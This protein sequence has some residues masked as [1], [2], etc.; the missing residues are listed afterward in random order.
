MA[1]TVNGHDVLFDNR[2]AGRLPRLRQW[3]VPGTDRH[4]FLRDGAM[5]FILIHIALWFHETVERLN[6]SGQVWD[7]WGW[8]VRPVR[9]QTSGYSNHAGGVAEDLNATLHPR[10]VPVTRTMT[11]KQI[12]RIRRRM[13]FMMAGVAIWGGG[14]NTPDGMHF[15]IAP[16]SL[17]RCELLAKLLMRTPRGKRILDVNPGAKKVIES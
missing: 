17:K 9:G 14:W 13:R 3:R 2:T 16:V 5:G 11:S 12:K 1:Q 8:A 4:L 7:E 6:L 15:E 10:G